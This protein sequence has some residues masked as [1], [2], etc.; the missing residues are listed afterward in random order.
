MTK[1]ANQQRE[2]ARSLNKTIC[3]PEAVD[4][5][6]TMKAARIFL[7]EGLGVPMLIGSQD[8]LLAMAEEA[9]TS[10]DGFVTIAPEASEHFDRAVALYQERRAKEKLTDEQARKV[11]SDPLMFGA[12]LVKMGVADGMTAGAINTTGNVIR[13]SIKCIGCRKGLRTVSSSFLMVLPDAEFGVDGALVFSDC[14]VIPA[15]TA[16]QLVDIG[17]AAAHTCR[18]M[19]NVEPVVAFLSFSTKGS[20]D[21]PDAAKMAEAAAKLSERCPDLQVDGE[22]QADSA[23]I[24][25]IGATKCPDSTVAGKANTLI[26]PDLGAGNIAY[27]LTQRLAKAEAYGPLLQGLAQPVNDLSR[28][29]STDDIVQVAAISALQTQ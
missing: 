27:K 1:L 6:R 2:I 22:L 8:Q 26:F 24:A 19:L 20:A 14:G 25:S 17:D 5:A 18:Q 13:A 28:G 16:D 7:D 11:V 9:G 21:H 12:L 10:L 15:P 23:L 29:C 4:D 3:L